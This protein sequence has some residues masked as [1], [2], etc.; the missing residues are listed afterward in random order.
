M[1]LR[2]GERVAGRVDDVVEFRRAA[3]LQ[4]GHDVGF[5]GGGGQVAGVAG[6]A[7]VGAR[8]GFEES[9]DAGVDARLLGRGD[10]D[11]GAVFE[12]GFGDAVADAGAAAD[13]EDAGAGELVG[14][15]FAVGHDGGCL[16]G[17][18]RINCRFQLR[19]AGLYN[20]TQGS[21]VV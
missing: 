10:D 13:D 16:A 2:H 21:D 4:Q 7:A 20:E 19:W 9:G 15:L 1:E 5:D 12:A 3:S 14:V 8:V 6:D 17:E 11:R 18:R